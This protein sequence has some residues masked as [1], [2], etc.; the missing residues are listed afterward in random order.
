MKI[1]ILLRLLVI[2][3]L[4]E[5]GGGVAR[6]GEAE[7]AMAAGQAALQRRDFDAALAS[8]S[9]A[10]RV[11][12]GD[13]L[14]YYYR[15]WTYRQKGDW[16]RV[17]SDCT[18]SLS[19]NANAPGTYFLRAMAYGNSKE[20]DRAFTDANTAVRLDPRY[21]EALCLRGTIFEQQGDME[22][23]LADY[24]LSIQLDPNYN[25]AYI[26]RARWYQNQGEA[27]LAAKYLAEA[28]R[29]NPD[30]ESV[31]NGVAW[32]LA[33]SP[34]ESMRNGAKALQYAQRACELTHWKNGGHL[35][36]LAAAYA[37]IGDFEQAVKWQQK[38]VELMPKGEHA[39]EVAQH[40]KL[41][42]QKQPY[43]ESPKLQAKP[44]GVHS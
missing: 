34:D 43:R 7:D 31:L 39:E 29:L 38:A 19:L 32:L 22:N 14:A 33:T 21:A 30:D 42:Q 27:A 15:A 5:L 3:G 1:T 11:N 44:D 35:D 6:A 23:S 12:P 17:I 10:I 26:A 13:G 40:L 25:Y 18:A 28:L 24:N 9:T 36:T 2:G 4:I 16:A 8:Y 20:F 37:E 41:Y